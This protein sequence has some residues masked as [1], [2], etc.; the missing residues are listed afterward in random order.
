MSQVLR[1]IQIIRV[2]QGNVALI[3]IQQR[4]GRGKSPWWREILI[5]Q[6]LVSHQWV[7]DIGKKLNR[8]PV[9]KDQFIGNKRGSAM[10]AAAACAG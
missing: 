9:V 2:Y 7:P 8:N 10:K 4:R 1:I 6:R 5:R 3:E